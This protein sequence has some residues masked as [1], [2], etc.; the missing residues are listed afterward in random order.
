MADWE[1]KLRKACALIE[2]VRNDIWETLGDDGQF[3][4]AADDGGLR[5]M[6]G[7]ARHLILAELPETPREAATRP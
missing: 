3:D 5:E 6:L 4:N 2:D 1:Q 7:L